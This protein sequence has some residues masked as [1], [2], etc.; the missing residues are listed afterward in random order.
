MGIV[1]CF[2]SYITKIFIS[3]FLDISKVFAFLGIFLVE[4]GERKGFWGLGERS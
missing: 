2:G 3:E 1:I 4:K